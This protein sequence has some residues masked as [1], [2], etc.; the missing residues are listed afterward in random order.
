M[1]VSEEADLNH[2]STA[3]QGKA[4]TTGGWP[5]R[6]EERRY[7]MVVLEEK[8]LTLESTAIQRRVFTTATMW[9]CEI[10]WS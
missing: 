2:K 4:F 9:S 5:T 6:T 3:G 1:V 10:E 8:G 7:G